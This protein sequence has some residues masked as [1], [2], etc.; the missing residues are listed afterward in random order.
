L[1]TATKMAKILPIG[2]LIL[3]LGLRL[4]QL[5]PALLELV[6]N[7]QLIDAELARALYE[8]GFKDAGLHLYGL[9]LY[10]YLVTV[11]Y[12]FMG[13][14]NEVAGRWLSVGASLAAAIIF[15]KLLRLFGSQFQALAGLVFFYLLSPV[16]IIISRSFLVDELTLLTGIAS[17]YFLARKS[18]WVGT[19]MMTLTLL[20]KFTFGYLLLPALWLTDKKKGLLLLLTVIPVLTWSVYV[21]HL[22]E[23]LIGGQSTGEYNLFYVFNPKNIVSAGFYINIFYHFARYAVTFLWLPLVIMGLVMKPNKQSIPFY[24][25]FLGAWGFILAF[26]VPSRTHSYYFLAL[27]PPVA[28]FAARATEWLRTHLKSQLWVPLPVIAMGLVALG[29]TG[30]VTDEFLKAYRIYEPYRQIPEAG[31]LIQNLTLPGDKIVTTADRTSGILYFSHRQGWELRLGALIDNQAID[32]LESLRLKGAKYYVV[33][34]AA[35]LLIKPLFNQYLNR[36]PVVKQI[37]KTRIYDLRNN[38]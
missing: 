35:E 5:S 7:R 23:Q 37:D 1:A 9:P 4:Y 22:N 20:S 34:D 12:F 36:F 31:R 29:L 24:L 10:H 27:V 17:L 30:V 26:N 33:Y 21:K 16:H 11:T 3:G 8:R 32:E 28:W 25:W 18:F 14:V 15:Y 13:G 38:N 19:V 6:P 2:I